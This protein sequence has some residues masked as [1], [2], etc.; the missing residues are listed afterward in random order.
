MNSGETLSSNTLF[1]FTGQ[2]EHLENII[3]NGFHPRYCTENFDM[4]SATFDHDQKIFEFGVPMV[5]FCDI[6]LS[7][8]KEHVSVYK[9]YGIGCTKAWGIEKGVTP[10]I[11]VKPDS[12]TVKGIQNALIALKSHSFADEN[13]A[14]TNAPI[15]R[16][17][18]ENLRRLIKFVKPYEGKFEHN[19]RTFEN[20]RFYD[21][22]EWRYVPSIPSSTAEILEWIDKY[23]INLNVKIV[24]MLKPQNIQT[25]SIFPGDLPWVAQN[26]LNNPGLANFSE[27][28]LS[29]E[30]YKKLADE[31]NQKI[32][33]IPEITLQIDP[34]TIK[35]II[36]EQEEDV[37]PIA[38]I[39]EK[40]FRD[41]YSATTLKRLMTRIIT[42]EQI[43]DDF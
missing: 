14:H 36:V 25:P 6:P 16:S 2:R 28:D 38:D 12:E 35:Y 18:R 34:L 13:D 4:F 17:V 23:S 43:Y 11:Y 7:K 10:L 26:L 3:N 32:A 24:Q 19:G 30:L 29:Q 20:K 15:V 27:L 31:M 22:R 37:V 41:V 40:K 39:L 33:S 21:E 5:C 9:G 1:H 8:V 42:L